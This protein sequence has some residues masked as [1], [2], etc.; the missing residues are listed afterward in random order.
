MVI[1]NG[2]NVLKLIYKRN[3]SKIIYKKYNNKSNR[4]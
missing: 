4:G 1:Y 2:E 3:S